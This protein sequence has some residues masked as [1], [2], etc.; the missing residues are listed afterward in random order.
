MGDGGPAGHHVA[1]SNSHVLDYTFGFVG[2]EER[3]PD[4]DEQDRSLGD[5]MV[6]RFRPDDRAGRRNRGAW[7]SARAR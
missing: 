4:P 5:D 2:A 3:Q 6:Y 7:L 1:D